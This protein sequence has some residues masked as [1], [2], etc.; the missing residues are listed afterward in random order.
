MRWSRCS[1]SFGFG[2]ALV[3]AACSSGRE[4]ASE[5]AVGEAPGSTPSA[6]RESVSAARRIDELRARFV[7]RPVAGAPPSVE[8]RPTSAEQP[9]IGAPVVE[10]FEPIGDRLGGPVRAVVAGA[11]RRGV[12]RTASVVL[13]GSADEAVELQDDKTR[14]AVRFSLM[15]AR[16][17]RLEIAGGFALYA[18]ALDGADLVHR[19][20]AE[21]TEDFIVFERRPAREVLEYEV[22]V[23]RVAGLRLVSNTLEFLDAAGSPGL[24]VAPPYW[25]DARGLQ[26]EARLSVTGCAYEAN[27]GAPWS[28]V[29]VRPGATRCSVVVTWTD[30]QYPIVVDPAWTTT[31]SLATARGGYEL[32]SAVLA[33]GR[34][35]IAGGTIAGGT[36][37]SSAELFDPTAAGGVGA[38]VATGAMTRARLEGPSANVLPSGKVLIVGGADAGGSRTSS[39]EIFDPAANA[40]AGAFSAAPSLTTGRSNHS[41]VA[42]ASG[43]ILIA[44]GLD[45]AG[46]RL[47]TAQIFDAAASGGT[48]AFADTGSLATPRQVAPAVLL[49]SG[50]VVVMGGNAQGYYLST[51]ELFDPAANGGLGAFGPTGAMASPRCSFGAT[52]L[53]SGKVL[54]AGGYVGSVMSTAELYDPSANGGAGAFSATGALSQ[55]RWGPLIGLR[56]GLVL[57]AGGDLLTFGTKTSTA[58]LFD[59]SANG[60]IGAFAPTVP[61][62]APR[63]GYGYARLASG[64]ILLAG[65]LTTSGV[66]STAEIY[67]FNAVGSPCAAPTECT[68]GY[69][70]DRCCNVACGGGSCDASGACK[71]KNGQSCSAASTCASGSCVDGV[72]CDGACTGACEACDVSGKT[73]TCSFASGAPHGSRS[74]NGVG[75]CAGS[76]NGAKAA[77]NYPSAGTACADACAGGTHTPFACDGSG[78][79]SAGAPASCG[80]YAC[81]ATTCKTSC[82]APSDCAA[83]FTCSGTSCVAIVADA[84]PDVADVGSIDTGVDS[85]SADS[86]GV[87]SAVADSSVPDSAAPD[88]GAGDATTDSGA[89][90]CTA[91]GASCGE[92]MTCTEDLRCVLGEATKTGCACELVGAG[93]GPSD[94]SLGGA[95]ACGLAVLAARR[96][97]RRLEVARPVGG[98][99][100]AG[101]D[102]KA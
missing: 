19:A 81:G 78:T 40:S 23:S 85:A 58:E 69:C 49:P 73:G 8:P 76:C 101:R 62:S 15:H 10:R 25:V 34:V 68:S 83:G 65:G 53:S 44:G 14:V 48:G 59:P 39:T 86:A 35:L 90:T 29:V 36:A 67:G 92:G 26:H 28:G 77:C 50:K 98:G 37:T 7:T 41:A 54:V 42:L 89:A 21:G 87:D 38:F 102:P 47:S 70:A 61:M 43:K 63:G 79:C 75:T 80:D 84:G 32:M 9:V 91:A 96:R 22:E 12:R 95:L 1:V 17:A 16:D 33:T 97:A 74:C 56:S 100:R 3:L 24:R 93:D 2:A 57:H 30:A 11:A 88:T 60:G 18:G 72:C 45:S 31:G 46:A 71:L 5:H 13:P 94:T 27:A 64:G 20:H 99:R 52:L 51:S 4:L 6:R 82:T 66:L 55:R